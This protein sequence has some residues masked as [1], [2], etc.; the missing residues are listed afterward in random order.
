M[1]MY[2]TYVFDTMLFDGMMLSDNINLSNKRLPTK[3]LCV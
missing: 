2:I 1:M 3:M